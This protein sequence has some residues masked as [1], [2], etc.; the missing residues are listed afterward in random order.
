MKAHVG[1]VEKESNSSVPAIRNEPCT[2]SDS[3]YLSELNSPKSRKEAI[4]EP[5]ALQTTL[6]GEFEGG[7]SSLASCTFGRVC[8]DVHGEL[9][10]GCRHSQ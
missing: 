3:M 7:R 6:W 2:F 8:M 5:L 9:P 1:L 10:V 4:L